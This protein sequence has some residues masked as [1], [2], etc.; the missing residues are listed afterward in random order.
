MRGVER[1]LGGG[2]F[3]QIDEEGGMNHRDS[4][5]ACPLPFPDQGVIQGPF[6]IALQTEG[7]GWM[8]Q[9]TSASQLLPSKSSHP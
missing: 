8:L 9:E 6:V 1:Q 2:L 5:T 3:P 7:E 4:K